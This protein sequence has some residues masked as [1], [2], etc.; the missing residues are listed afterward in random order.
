MPL[1]LLKPLCLAC[2]P[3]LGLNAAALAQTAPVPETLALFDGKSLAGWKATDFYEPG[4][5]VVEDGAIL[6]KQG[7]KMTGFTSTRTDL[8]TT[9]YELSFD[10]K[11][12]EGADFFAAATFPVGKSFITLVNGGW[13]GSV[14][15]LSSLDG[16][17]AHENDT[18]RSFRYMNGKWYHF[19]VHV[20]DKTIYAWID[21]KLVVRVSHEG[22]HVSTRIESRRSQPLG[23]ATY[24]TTGA[25]KAIAVRP[26]TPGE[27]ETANQPIE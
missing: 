9:N 20:T 13:G 26:L 5:V 15:G 4:E 8:P 6:M 17:D 11:R 1:H 2:L 24:E 25:V 12:V 10:A 16:S 14:T 22:R 21:D 23:F 7:T 27:I 19:R 3:L 18:G